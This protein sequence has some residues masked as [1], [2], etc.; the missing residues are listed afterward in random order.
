MG[1]NYNGE[2]SAGGIIP[3]VMR[4]IF[5]RVQDLKDESNEFLIRVSFIEV[6]IMSSLVDFVFVGLKLVIF[7][8]VL[9]KK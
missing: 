5:K 8:L 6:K 9:L 7:K 1:T 4:T 3:N 2:E